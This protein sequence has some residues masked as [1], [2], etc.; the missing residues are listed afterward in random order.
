MKKILA[1]LFITLFTITTY[2]QESEF[3]KMMREMYKSEFV[4]VVNENMNLN[5]TQ[6]A[7]FLPIFTDFLAELGAVMDAKLASQAKFADYFNTMTDEQVNSLFKEI[8]SNSK[9]YDK[10][11]KKYSKKVS[12]AVGPQ[13]AFRFF[14]I[15][16]KVQSNIEFSVIQNIPLVKN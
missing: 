16:Q 12:K 15:V 7:A 5:E 13:S 9:S 6:N 10:L 3:T 11:L 4:D 8:W 1:V 2:A 14:L